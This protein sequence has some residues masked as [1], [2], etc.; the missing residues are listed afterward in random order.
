M[1]TEELASEPTHSGAATVV[2]PPVN[3]F[4]LAFEN[5][6]DM[7]RSDRDTDGPGKMDLKLSYTDSKDEDR[8]AFIKHF[9]DYVE[10]VKRSHESKDGQTYVKLCMR[11]EAVVNTGKMVED[12]MTRQNIEECIKLLR[13][14]E[15]KE[16]VSEQ[17]RVQ[18]PA[19]TKLGIDLPEVVAP[20]WRSG[21]AKKADV[22]DKRKDSKKKEPAAPAGEEVSKK[23]T[24]EAHNAERAKNS[25]NKVPPPDAKKDKQCKYCFTQMWHSPDRCFTGS[26]DAHVPQDFHKK[27][28]HSIH[29][30]EV[31]NATMRE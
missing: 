22:G 23:P 12:S 5:L 10:R 26:R 15:Y 6:K 25:Y 31:N 11:K 3:N 28:L 24:R 2:T 21:A 7:E 8:A 29:E 30:H 1:S 13:I 9:V 18:F 20:I 14:R 27:R 17:L 19:P 4:L 16:R